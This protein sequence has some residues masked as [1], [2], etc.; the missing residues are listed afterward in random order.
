MDIIKI[1]RD[2][3]IKP[4]AQRIAIIE[5]IINSKRHPTIEEI[6]ENVSKQLKALSLTTVYSTLSLLEEKG[7]LKCLF[8]GKERRYDIVTP[9][10]FHF[11]CEKCG[12]IFDV[13]DY[14]MPDIKEVEG[15]LIKDMEIIFKGICFKCRK[16]S[17]NG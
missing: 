12:N 15:N 9:Y 11:I 8:D 6:F 10:H 16:G 3:K 5:F 14:K 1:L 17:K 13:Y 4:S 7:V 2:K